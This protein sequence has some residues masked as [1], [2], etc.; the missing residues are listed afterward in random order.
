MTDQPFMSKFNHKRRFGRTAP[1]DAEGE[2]AIQ[3][4]KKCMKEIQE[5][6]PHISTGALQRMALEHCAECNLEPAG[7]REK[8]PADFLR[9]MMTKLRIGKDRGEDSAREDELGSTV[10]SS[11]CASDLSP[12]QR[13]TLAARQRSVA[14]IS[15]DE[16]RKFLDQTKNDIFGSEEGL[17]DSLDDIEKSFNLF[18]KSPTRRTSK[19][20]LYAEG[21]RASS[22]RASAISL[23][24]SDVEEDD[25]LKHSGKQ[26]EE[27]AI[28]V[29]SSSWTCNDSAEKNHNFNQSVTDILPDEIKLVLNNF[30]P[31]SKDFKSPIPSRSNNSQHNS[32]DSHQSNGNTDGNSRNNDSSPFMDSFLSVDSDNFEGDFSAWN[33]FRGQNSS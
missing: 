2:N 26:T 33:S 31:G 25:E 10:S 7:R 30:K 23:N 6:N 12:H 17:Q 13:R 1:A 27:G 21:R 4:Y 15:D 3:E 28:D 18:E 32:V 19:R 5:H 24:L 20:F 14:S 29:P 9:G 11:K 22:R 8:R 16:H